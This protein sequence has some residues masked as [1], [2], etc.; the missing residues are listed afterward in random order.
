[1]ASN[2]IDAPETRGEFK[3][4]IERN[5][6]K[7][8]IVYATASWCKPCRKIKP[9]IFK[10]F[11]SINDPTKILMV[12]DVDRCADVSRYLRIRRVPQLSYY[13]KGEP[14]YVVIGGNQSEVQQFFGKIV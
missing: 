9:Y 5:K 4:F 3:T 6:N 12:L 2:I 8:V 1:M 10:L 11:E 14:T 7:G 13:D